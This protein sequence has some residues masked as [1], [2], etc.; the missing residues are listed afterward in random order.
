[1][2]GL[3]LFLLILKSTSV[4]AQEISLSEARLLYQKAAKERSAA[5][6]LLD[7]L[8]HV[9]KEKPILLAYKAGVTMMMA[10]YTFLPFGKLKRF[11]EGKKLLQQAIN[12]GPEEV[13]I[14][15]LRFSLQS[16]TPG[17]LGYKD[18]MESDKDFLLSKFPS[19]QDAEL[20]ALMLPFL[21]N[22]DYLT[23]DEKNS[24]SG[25]PGRE[26]AKRKE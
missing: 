8:E 1:M 6:E 14:R 9:N 21:L 11:N 5:E 19:L 16:E 23:E 25:V 15:F 10:K 12:A 20:K 4:I 22:S 17:F 2:K 13:E 3:F 18:N 26:E 7:R 24:L